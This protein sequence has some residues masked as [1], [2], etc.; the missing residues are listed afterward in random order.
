ML[1][2][3]LPGSGCSR[4]LIVVENNPGTDEVIE[5]RSVSEHGAEKEPE[6]NRENPYAF[7]LR[8]TECVE[9]EPP[10]LVLL[11]T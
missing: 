6:E 9:N 1:R 8:N 5:I 3:H 7:F 4:I 10:G 2:R 11:L